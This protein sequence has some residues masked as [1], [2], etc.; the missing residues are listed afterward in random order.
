MCVSE[1]RAIVGG[2]ASKSN[3]HVAGDGYKQVDPGRIGAAANRTGEVVSPKTPDTR[4]VHRKCQHKAGGIIK[5]IAPCAA[6]TC[7]SSEL[8]QILLWSISSAAQRTDYDIRTASRQLPHA[9][10]NGPAEFRSVMGELDHYALA[11]GFVVSTS[12]QSLSVPTQLPQSVRV[13]FSMV[14]VPS[15]RQSVITACDTLTIH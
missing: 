10:H 2:Y 4:P 13:F 14:L 8:H 3:I 1:I 9:I 15:N 11:Q 7:N 6:R 12:V 5:N